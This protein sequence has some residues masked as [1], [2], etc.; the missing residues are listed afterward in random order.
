MTSLNLPVDGSQKESDQQHGTLSWV[1]GVCGGHALAELVEQGGH[2]V[3]QPGHRDAS[4]Q[5]HGV[6]T[7]VPHRLD[8]VVNVDQMHL[9][10][11]KKTV[12]SWV[13][14]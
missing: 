8:H 14:R 9:N 5:L 3:L 13:K 6:Q 11:K 4:V 7:S 1:D 2:Q 10:E 12:G